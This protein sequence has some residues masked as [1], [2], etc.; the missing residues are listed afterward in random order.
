MSLGDFK[1]SLSKGRSEHLP[2]SLGGKGGSPVPREGALLFA[3]KVDVALAVLHRGG[4]N[5]WNRVLRLG[6]L[7][8]CVIHSRLETDYDGVV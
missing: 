1:R 6:G 5:G 3:D 2:Y 4:T 8:G 7:L